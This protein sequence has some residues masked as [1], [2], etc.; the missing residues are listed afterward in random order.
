MNP[1]E[2]I[3]VTPEDEA[4]GV[5]EKMEAHQKGVLHRAFSVFLFDKEGRM[6]LQQRA[7]QKYHGAY[8]WTNAC[9]S[10]PMR[11]EPVEQAAQRRLMEELGF[12]TPLN[13]I[14][15]FTYKATVENNLVEHEYD[16]VFAGEYEG[17]VK[18][19]PEEVCDYAYV[20]LASIKN[21]LQEEP[22]RF[23]S[24]FRIAFPEIEAWW[25]AQYGERQQGVNRIREQENN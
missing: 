23:T 2:V 7:P 22:E 12:Q 1:N 18:M 11:D 5:M 24:W 3:L 13:K 19:N 10:H 4:I 21:R 9:C 16:H 8:L 20:D 14:F 15:T 25:K 17:P 6:L